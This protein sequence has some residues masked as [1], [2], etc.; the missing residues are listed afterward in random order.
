MSTEGLTDGNSI[1]RCKVTLSVTRCC[2]AHATS[3][4]LHGEKRTAKERSICQYIQAV[5]SYS[6][7]ASQDVPRR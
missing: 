5:A 2:D 3:R 7:S 1:L 4:N 6:R